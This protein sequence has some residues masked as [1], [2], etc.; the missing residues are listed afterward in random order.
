MTV[1]LTV[2]PLPA[3]FLPA[4]FLL[5]EIDSCDEKV[6][7]RIDSIRAMLIPFVNSR[8]CF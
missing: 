6:A 1:D 4:L 3:V 8:H 5:L 2:L 7:L